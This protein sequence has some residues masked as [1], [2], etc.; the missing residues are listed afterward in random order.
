MSPEIYGAW[1][2]LAIHATPQVIAAGFAHP[3]DGQ[4]AGEVATIVKLVPPFVLFFLL[5]ALL[6]TS[7][8]FPE[9]TFHMTDRFLFGAGDRTM[10]LAQVL[11]LTAGWLITTAI[12]GVGLLTEFRALRLGGGR[13]IALGVGCSVV[14]A[15][16]AFIYVS[17][18]M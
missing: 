7:G 9:V 2:G 10:N 4:T 16:V 17:V 3:V 18:S 12:A 5:A 11:G 13:P 14:A 8:F 1:C 15:V 6:R